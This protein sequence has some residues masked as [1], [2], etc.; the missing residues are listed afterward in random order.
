MWEFI[1][2][3]ER[4]DEDRAYQAVSY[5]EQLLAS[6][7]ANAGAALAALALI[8]EYDVDCSTDSFREYIDEIGGEED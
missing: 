5:L 3:E 1:V 8:D 4:D 2:R 6:G 7:L